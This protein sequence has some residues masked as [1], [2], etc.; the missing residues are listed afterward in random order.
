M[1]G[2]A[3]FNLKT[4][5]NFILFFIL[6]LNINFYL[7]SQ[8]SFNKGIDV[9]K[10]INH[11]GPIILY[12]DT[13]LCMGIGVD[14]DTFDYY[15][16]FM[17]KI[18]LNGNFIRRYIDIEPLRLYFY[19]DNNN[20]FVTGDTLIVGIGNTFNIDADG[21]LML[22][23][24]NSGEIL[25]KIPFESQIDES[26]FLHDM[27]RI[28]DSLFALVLTVQE[29]PNSKYADGQI[30][31][32][33]IKTDSVKYLIFGKKDISDNPTFLHWTGSSFLVGTGYLDPPFVI[34]Q[35]IKR[36]IEGIIYEVDLAVLKNKIN[37]V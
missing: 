34:G 37:N 13:L 1:S 18:D 21:Y 7:V 3:C 12:K 25:K 2:R 16:A 22:F 14:H 10:H 5:K 29:T 30:C 8:P 4:M 23:N 33:N 17:A 15:A 11:K 19:N 36:N 9:M 31:I 20:A 35:Y 32:I 6:L 24:I 26:A 27:I 28:N